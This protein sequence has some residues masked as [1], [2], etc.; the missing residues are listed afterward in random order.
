MTSNFVRLYFEYREVSKVEP[1]FQLNWIKIKAS[2]GSYVLGG[3]IYPKVGSGMVIPWGNDKKVAPSL[4]YLL[5]MVRIGEDDKIWGIAGNTPAG[6]LGRCI[7]EKDER[8]WL[9]KVFAPKN[10]KNLKRF[11]NVS[12]NDRR[13]LKKKFY[14]VRWLTRFIS[15]KGIEIY[16]AGYPQDL[17]A[18]IESID[19]VDYHE[20]HDA[21]LIHFIYSELQKFWPRVWRNP[22]GNLERKKNEL[23]G[24]FVTSKKYKEVKSFFIS[25]K[26]PRRNSIK[27]FLFGPH[28]CGK[29]EIALKLACEYED[30][31]RGKVFWIDAESS[32]SIFVSCSEIALKMYNDKAITLKEAKQTPVEC[33]T[34]FLKVDGGYL[35]IL[36]NVKDWNLVDQFIPRERNG[37][38]LVTTLKGSGGK[39]VRDDGIEVEW[40]RNE[41]K[42]LL[43]R[44]S[45]VKNY[46]DDDADKLYEALSDLPLFI[47]SAAAVVEN[48]KGVLDFKEYLNLLT[49]RTEETLKN[50][51]ENVRGLEQSGWEIYEIAL[52]AMEKRKNSGEDAKAI[53]AVCCLLYRETI[54]ELVLRETIIDSIRFQNAINTLFE[55]SLLKYDRGSK[56]FT[57]HNLIQKILKIMICGDNELEWAKQ[58]LLAFQGGLNALPK[59]GSNFVNEW[60]HVKYFIPHAIMLSRY[61]TREE[62][63]DLEENTLL[64]IIFAF[65]RL[66]ERYGVDRQAN[67]LCQKYV[68]LLITRTLR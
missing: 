5:L 37:H 60:N 6:H 11:F 51:G 29:S 63:I 44:R 21:K 59:F 2:T 54:P 30:S 9:L 10:V 49:T 25:R 28:G 39:F 48:A 58:A 13:D 12:K 7:D 34:D 14:T 31:Y 64:K 22:R 4:A 55:F 43:I 57:I 32:E 68:Y 35:L 61:L 23:S 24:F 41:S 36:D 52:E 67:L 50:L 45:K 19:G 18:K 20:I 3:N 42:E 47:E 62:N 66:L 15:Q 53:L 1:K 26:S 46:I 16:V 65:G 8:H 56:T 33:V 27:K 17:K 40:E 38:I